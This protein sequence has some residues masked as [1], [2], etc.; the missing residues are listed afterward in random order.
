MHTMIRAGGAITAAIAINAAI[1]LVG[2]LAGADYLVPKGPEQVLGPLGLGAVLGI[3]AAAMAVGTLLWLGLQKLTEAKA[4]PIFLALSGIAVVLSF[5][6]F[7]SEFA[8]STKL[9]LSPMHFIPPAA[10]IWALG[11]TRS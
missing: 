7:A 3:T 2:G 1:Y 4:W 10:L 9:W 8:L 6:P 11:P 5:V